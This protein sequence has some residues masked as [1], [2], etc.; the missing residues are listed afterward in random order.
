MANST[1]EDG[2]AIAR[3]ASTTGAVQLRGAM[4]PWTSRLFLE[5]VVQSDRGIVPGAMAPTTKIDHMRAWVAMG[6]PFRSWVAEARLCAEDDKAPREP[7]TDDRIDED[8]HWLRMAAAI[9]AGPARRA[10]R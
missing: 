6:D 1:N 7:W 8:G 10:R 9:M 5:M 3:S 2:G 4:P